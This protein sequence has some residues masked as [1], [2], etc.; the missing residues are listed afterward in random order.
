[1]DWRVARISSASERNDTGRWWVRFQW[2][3]GQCRNLLPVIGLGAPYREGGLKSAAC[4][5]RDLSSRDKNPGPS[6]K[7]S[8]RHGAV[9]D[10]RQLS[11]CKTCR[12]PGPPLSRLRHHKNACAD[13]PTGIFT[14]VL[15]QVIVRGLN[16]LNC[17]AEDESICII[18]EETSRLLF[19]VL[20]C[21]RRQD[22]AFQPA[23][24]GSC[25]R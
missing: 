19:H 3:Y 14:E 22:P 9:L 24:R 21:G 25:W 6:V 15:V 18:S 17:I 7:D 13:C 10:D 23:H 2:A 12:R 8:S 20:R 4:V 16:Q 5:S 1:M 11:G